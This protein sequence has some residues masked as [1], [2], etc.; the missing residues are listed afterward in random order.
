MNKEEL[1]NK[2]IEMIKEGYELSK[3][4][5]SKEDLLKVYI[6]TKSNLE[7]IKPV[8]ELKGGSNE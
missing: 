3:D 4:E 5:V 6:E 2:I 8:Q 7:T 1:I